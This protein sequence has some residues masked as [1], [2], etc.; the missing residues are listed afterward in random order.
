MAGMRPVHIEKPQPC[1]ASG[2][3]IPKN[4]QASKPCLKRIPALHLVHTH[5][6]S[7]RIA[8]DGLLTVPGGII[9]ERRE[10]LLYG[11]LW[12]KLK[13]SSRAKPESHDQ[14]ERK[15]AP[16]VN[17]GYRQSYAFMCLCLLMGWLGLVYCLP[18]RA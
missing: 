2:A 4:T 10:G 3:Y 17:R 8:R 6:E 12:W 1:I 7:L 18:I 15:K 9:P 11:L 14:P 13:R 5:P 16:A